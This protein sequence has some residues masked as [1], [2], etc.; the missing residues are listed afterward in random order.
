MRAL[1][2]ALG[3]TLAT[4][5]NR[6]KKGMPV[7]SIA[8]AAAWSGKRFEENGGA[9]SSQSAAPPD[10]RA[11]KLSAEIARIQEAERKLRMENDLTEGRLV[12]VES[13]ERI[14]AGMVLDL[15]QQFEGLAERLR[16]RIPP[17]IADDIVE[18]VDRLIRMELTRFAEW[19]PQWIEAEETSEPEPFEL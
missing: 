13:V 5:A 10:L 2:E 17:D 11:A 9:G 18:D 7:D 14:L 12:D 19:R 3:V 8:A 16:P 1:A 15:R 4:V 6:R